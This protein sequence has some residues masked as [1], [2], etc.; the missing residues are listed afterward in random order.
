MNSQAGALELPKF[1]NRSLGTRGR[2]GTRKTLQNE[3]KFIYPK[4]F[5]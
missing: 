1:Q 4:I 2:C 5:C 3:I